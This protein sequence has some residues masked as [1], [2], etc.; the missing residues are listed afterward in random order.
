MKVCNRH[1]LTAILKSIQPYGPLEWSEKIEIH[2]PT[3]S[4]II[5]RNVTYHC[6]IIRS[7]EFLTSSVLFIVSAVPTDLADQP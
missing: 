1:L 2:V 3:N 6:S 4:L 7:H 5:I